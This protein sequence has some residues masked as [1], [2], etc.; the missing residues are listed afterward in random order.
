MGQ[1]TPNIGIYIPSAGETNYD[2]S[3]SQGM[4]NIDQHDHSGGPNKGVPLS[5][6]GIDDGAITRTKLN[7]DVVSAGEGLAIDLSNPNALK[8]D[9]LLN[10]IYKLNTNGFIV[11]TG[12]ARSASRTFQDNSQFTWNKIS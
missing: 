7:T 8:A 11:R 1:L 10:A 2:S 5:S 4:F 3:F 9:A 12:S 6:S